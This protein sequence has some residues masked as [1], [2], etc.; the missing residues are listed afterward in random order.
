MVICG[1]RKEDYL[2]YAHCLTE[3]TVFHSQIHP[4]QHRLRFACGLDP[5][6]VCCQSV[7]SVRVI[8]FKTVI[9]PPLWWIGSHW[10]V[11][12]L[13]R[14]TFPSVSPSLSACQ[15]GRWQQGPP[16]DRRLPVKLHLLSSVENPPHQLYFKTVTLLSRQ[17]LWQKGEASPIKHQKRPLQW[18]HKWGGPCQSL[19]PFF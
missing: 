4:F 13:A 9:E 16:W 6:S 14:L 5:V 19:H 2:G 7:A 8:A 3:V 17:R 11:C 1:A 10:R 15:D 12:H 18:K